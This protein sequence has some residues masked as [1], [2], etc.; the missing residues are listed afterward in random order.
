[1]KADW[2]NSRAS[3]NNFLPTL[4]LISTSKR[5]LCSFCAGFCLKTSK[6]FSL[7]RTSYLHKRVLHFSFRLRKIPENPT[8]SEQ[9]PRTT[10][11]L[12]IGQRCGRNIFQRPP[13]R[14][15]APKASSRR[16]SNCHFGAWSSSKRSSSLRWSKLSQKTIPK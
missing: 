6:V 8:R 14:E 12:R 16:H 7:R 1:M 9:A 11:R 15:D 13:E 3:W 4:N 5:I 10:I 2:S